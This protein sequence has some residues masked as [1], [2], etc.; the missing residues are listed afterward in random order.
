MRFED[1]EG[2]MLTQYYKAY[3]LNEEK[4]EVVQKEIDALRPGDSMV[5]MN[6]DN[7]TKDIVDYILNEIIR[8]DVTGGETEKKLCDVQA[9]EK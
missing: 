2:A 1:G 9:M 5:I 7:N 6:R 8:S 3:V 4:D